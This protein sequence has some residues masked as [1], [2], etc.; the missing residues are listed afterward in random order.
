[1]SVFRVSQ[2]EPGERIANGMANIAVGMV[3]DFLVRRVYLV[4]LGAVES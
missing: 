2:A 1:M 4:E 3:G